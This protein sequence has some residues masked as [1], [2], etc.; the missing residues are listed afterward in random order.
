MSDHTGG[1]QPR[2][3]EPGE[4]SRKAYVGK[5][6]E[7]SF[8]GELCQHAAECVKGA[9]RVFDTAKRPWIDP[10]GDTPDHE[11]EVIARCPSG[12]LRYARVG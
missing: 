1:H 2:T 5:H 9:P 4:E 10:D 6:S 8:D 11:A 12:A 7:I 3:V